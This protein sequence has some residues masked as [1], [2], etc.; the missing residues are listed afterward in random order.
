MLNDEKLMEE[1]LGN[2]DDVVRR[3]LGGSLPDTITLTMCAAGIPRKHRQKVFA[4]FLKT[5]RDMDAAFDFQG[6]WQPQS[7]TLS[8]SLL[9]GIGRCSGY[10]EKD[11]TIVKALM[12]DW[13][14]LA[15]W[16]RRFCDKFKSVEDPFPGASIKYEEWYC[17]LFLT[18]MLA[19]ADD[20]RA[21]KMFSVYDVRHTMC[22][23]WLLETPETLS[24]FNSVHTQLVKMFALHQFRYSA[25]FTA[26]LVR[27]S[28]FG[29]ERAMQLVMD[30]MADALNSGNSEVMCNN[31]FIV[32]FLVS[33][34]HDSIRSI[35]LKKKAIPYLTKAFVKTTDPKTI[36]RTEK[37]PDFVQNFIRGFE[38]IT[39]PEG[40]YRYILQALRNGFLHGVIACGALMDRLQWDTIMALKRIIGNVLIKYLVYLP[41][42]LGVLDAMKAVKCKDIEECIDKSEVKSHWSQFEETLLARTVYKSL[43]EHSGQSNLGIIRCANCGK[44]DAKQNLQKC[45]GC[46]NVF[47]CS[48]DCQRT[49][50]KQGGHRLTCKDTPEEMRGYDR[51]DQRYRDFVT[52]FEVRRHMK[53]L[54]QQAVKKFNLKVSPPEE[55]L[56][57]GCKIDYTSVPPTLSIFSLDDIPHAQDTYS[58]DT[59]R[60]KRIAGQK[61]E[62]MCL[63]Q[64]LIPEGKTSLSQIKYMNVGPRSEI[65]GTDLDAQQMAPNLSHRPPCA[66]KDGVLVKAVLDQ[67]DVVINDLSARK[68]RVGTH[69][70]WGSCDNRFEKHV[71]V[72]E[73]MDDTAKSLYGRYGEEHLFRNVARETKVAQSP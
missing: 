3:A 2:V 28:G 37:L 12:K 26:E 22:R 1:M 59:E 51:R 43:F 13:N 30:R 52:R 65:W 20:D 56:S 73:E 69:Y 67:I 31:A 6:V 29:E 45:G 36:R 66:G 24:R 63:V 15:R 25:D 58:T 23:L 48:K 39:S 50:W 54:R 55:N 8:L 38:F 71:T 41:Y 70:R 42:L 62:Q 35:A 46:K 19:T 17:G 7:A 16:T 21:H 64:T 44:M 49:H 27:D 72:V 34:Q 9:N 14:M 11:D 57:Y 40:G 61:G 53:G 10:L 32:L 4:L 60:M 18:I 68:A 47:Y 33:S 5:L